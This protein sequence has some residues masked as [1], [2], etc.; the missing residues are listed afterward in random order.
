MEE[1]LAE[2]L[3]LQHIECEDLGTIGPAMSKRGIGYRYVRLFD[4]ELL[5]KGLQQ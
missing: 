1:D 4:G 3:V 2:F 5:P